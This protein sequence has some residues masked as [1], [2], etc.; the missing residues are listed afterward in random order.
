MM[1]AM[2]TT[3]SKTR[4]LALLENYGKDT[5]FAG[6]LWRTMGATSR[7]DPVDER[8]RNF[9][10]V[11]AVNKI[12]QDAD[13]AAVRIL[14]LTFENARTFLERSFL[15]LTTKILR[16]HHCATAIR[17]HESAVVP[18]TAPHGMN[19][20]GSLKDNQHLSIIKIAM[21]SFFN[22]HLH[23]TTAASSATFDIHQ[24]ASSPPS[25]S[26]VASPSNIKP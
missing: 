13:D 7:H 6:E 10:V 17:L 19:M 2:E 5:C 9:R 23:T 12:R 16:K 22:D 20:I 11:H 18:H 1:I 25:S 21:P 4:G 26:N 3:C 8:K 15:V 14:T 24:G